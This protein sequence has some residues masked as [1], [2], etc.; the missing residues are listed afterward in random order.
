MTNHGMSEA[1]VYFRA[2]GGGEMEEG[3][4]HFKVGPGKGVSLQAEGRR[5]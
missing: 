3:R 5:P 1:N 4:G 2:D